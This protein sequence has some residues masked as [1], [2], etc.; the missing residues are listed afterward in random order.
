VLATLLLYV[1]IGVMPVWMIPLHVICHRLLGTV[2]LQP[3]VQV[4]ALI[5][6]V[7]A[8]ALYVTLLF[9]LSSIFW[10]TSGSDVIAG[11]V[12]VALTVNAMAL[13][14]FQ[15]V[16][17]ALTSIHMAVLLRISWAGTLPLDKLL[18]GYDREY[19]L[20]ERIQRLV[21]LRQVTFD[22]KAVRLRSHTLIALSAPIYLWRRILG[23]SSET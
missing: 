3:S 5:A 8:N 20:G 17:V 14:Y 15:L 19:M 13:F 10:P 16:N 11:V 9:S 2:H 21:Q 22:G 4:S 18:S 1:S 23:L 7:M 6:A 12:F